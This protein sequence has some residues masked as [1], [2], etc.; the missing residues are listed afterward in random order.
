MVTYKG[1]HRRKKPGKVNKLE[2]IIILSQQAGIE[3]MQAYAK[4]D[5]DKKKQ[6]EESKGQTTKSRRG[7][8]DGK[9]RD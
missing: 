1:H 2:L 8:S 9:K 7:T 5:V 6:D 3:R 4:Q